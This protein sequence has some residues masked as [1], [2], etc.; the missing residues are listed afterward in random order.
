MSTKQQ[1][2]NHHSAQSSASAQLSRSPSL[3]RRILGVAAVLVVI[4][5]LTLGFLAVRQYEYDRGIEAGKAEQQENT[6][7]RLATLA[8]A[9]SEKQSI[10]DQ[11]NN[12]PTAE[13]N[14]DSIENY[15]SALK[16]VTSNLT[17]QIANSDLE[18]YQK[19]WQDFAET[20]KSEDNA[21]IDEAFKNLQTSAAETAKKLQSHYDGIIIS[22]LEQL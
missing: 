19:A 18:T 4:A 13:L 3:F 16:T 6:R 10:A 11:L 20:Y 8:D 7:E 21:K 22:I 1:S 17:D 2:Q 14:A 9:I 5:L 15:L 12:L